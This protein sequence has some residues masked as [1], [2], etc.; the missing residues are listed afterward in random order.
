MYCCIHCLT[1]KE[2]E[3]ASSIERLFHQNGMDDTIVWFPKKV[4]RLRVKGKISEE[5]RPLF[6]GYIF[7]FFGY[8]QDALP[9]FDIRRTPFVVRILTYGDGTIDLRGPD[10]SV[11]KWIHRNGGDIAISKVVYNPGEKLH[12]VDG[13]MQGLDALV[14]KVDRHKKKVWVSFDLDGIMNKVSF[15]VDFL[16]GG[17]ASKLPY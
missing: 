14:V 11:A 2:P 4:T 16:Q 15:D 9:A 6:P 8:E 1:G 5:M 17:G 13:P 7:F 10:L 3:A 12:I